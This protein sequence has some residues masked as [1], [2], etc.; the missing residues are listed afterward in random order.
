MTLETDFRR[1]CQ[2][3]GWNDP[4]QRGLIAV[5]T[6]VDSMVLLALFCQLPVAVRPQLTVVHVNHQLREQ[7]K[8]EAAF[9][10]QWCYDHQLPLVATVWPRDQQPTHGTE[11]AA[12]K[13]RYAF[14]MQQLAAQHADWVATAHQADEQAETILLKLIRGGQ[15]SQLTGMA[16][17]RPLG[18]GR[19]IHPLLPFTKQMLQD[20][21]VTHQIPWYEDATNQELIASRNRIRH[22]ILPALRQE[23]PQVDQHLREYAQQLQATLVVADQAVDDRLAQ[24]VSQ[25]APVTGDVQRLLTLSTAD[26]QLLLARLIKQTAP[27]ITASASH[28][29]ACLRLLN[30]REHP[31]GTVGFG[32]G[33]QLTK[34]YDSFRFWQPKI[35]VEKSVEHF[36]FMVDLNQWQPV[37]NGWQLGFFPAE[38]VTE[39]SEHETIALSTAQLPLEIRSFRA[40]DRLRLADG[41]HQAVRRVLI[42]AKVPRDRRTQT[43][44]LVTA[45]GDVLAVLGVKW[46]VWP[47]R[48]HTKNYHIVLKYE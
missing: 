5:S 40:T 35:F 36:S 18:S 29:A 42:N 6:G 25:W 16:P 38:T 30:S 27:A 41:H 20:Y 47:P 10:E 43:P 8:T 26:Q 11:A 2:R 14:F 21:A 44:V 1:N 12:R 15:L 34:R 28:L 22:V 24:I 46:A 37:G 9:L 4:R 45:Q 7:S 19:V 48:P 32:Q 33:W 39:Y 31:T 3:Y 13:F 17:Q 23:N